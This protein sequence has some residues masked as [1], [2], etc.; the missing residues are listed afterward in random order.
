M[1]QVQL[2]VFE[3]N[4]ETYR[5]TF[6]TKANEIVIKFES[7]LGLG[8]SK[9]IVVFKSKMSES[10]NNVTKE[11]AELKQEVTLLEEAVAQEGQECETEYVAIENGDQEEPPLAFI[12]YHDDCTTLELIEMLWNRSS[13]SERMTACGFQSEGYETTLGEEN[14][15]L[16]QKVTLLE[17]AVAQ[18]QLERC[19]LRQQNTGLSV[20]VKMLGEQIKDNEATFNLR[21]KNADYLVKRHIILVEQNDIMKQKLVQIAER[22]GKLDLFYNLLSPKRKV[23]LDHDWRDFV[24]KWMDDLNEWMKDEDEE[25]AEEEEDVDDVDAPNVYPYKKCSECS[26]RKSCGNYTNEKKWCCEDCYEEE[27]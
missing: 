17:E 21:S 20:T 18:L 2:L 19:S 16:K 8:N 1:I 12:H 25:E 6:L 22:Y 23:S 14:A 7:K 4:K 9:S 13:E 10:Q 27:E 24:N 5:A 3:S 11:N 15:K 26:E